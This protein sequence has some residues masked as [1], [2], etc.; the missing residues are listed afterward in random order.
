MIINIISIILAIL[1]MVAI[2]VIVNLYNKILQFEKYFLS[3][4]YKLIE[5]LKN[6]NT[7][8]SMKMFEEDDEVGILWDGVKDIL[9][10]LKEIIIN[11]KLNEGE[12]DNKIE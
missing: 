10:D 6:L 1:F 8:D 5:I 7:L 11:G 3:V 12:N 2:Y 9:F 4:N